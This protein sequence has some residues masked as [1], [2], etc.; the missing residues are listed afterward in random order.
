[1]EAAPRRWGWALALFVFLT[2]DALLVQWTGLRM[3]LFPP[4]VVIAFE[5]FSH[6][7]ICPWARRPLRLPLAC[8]L[9]A[10]IGWLAVRHLGPGVV[11][12]MVSFSLAIGV[13][14]GLDLHVPPALAVA[15]IPQVMPAPDW[16]YPVSV[17]GGAAL[18]VAVFFVSRPYLAQEPT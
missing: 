15:L 2:V 10:V 11:P 18:L 5:M 12:T 7:T 9:T 3:L 16:R 13:L 6:P 1:M 14:R 17:T 8:G 4:L